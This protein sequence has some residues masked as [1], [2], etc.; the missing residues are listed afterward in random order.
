MTTILVIVGPSG[1]GKTTLSA[2]LEEKGIPK[3]TTTTTRPQRPNEIDG[4]DYNF[5]SKD[6]F[7]EALEAG[8]FI[9]HATYNDNMYGCTKFDIERALANADAS[10]APAVSIVMEIEGLFAMRSVCGH[11]G[12]VRC[13]FMS[14]DPAKIIERL[15]ARGMTDDDL[16]YRRS[17]ILNEAANIKHLLPSDMIIGDH[18]LDELDELSSMIAGDPAYQ[19]HDEA[20]EEHIS[21]DAAL[22]SLN[23]QKSPGDFSGVSP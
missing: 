16:A 6:A 19:E 18:T 13:L 22:A 1:S 2:F 23:G 5:I 15:N 7:Y 10:D 20:A 12:N 17:A 4:I 21:I 3:V 11:E 8:D 9:E 14:P